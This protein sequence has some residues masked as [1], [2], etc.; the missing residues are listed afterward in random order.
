MSK[1]FFPF[2]FS[3]GILAGNVAATIA[4]KHPVK[5]FYN[6]YGSKGV[7]LGAKVLKSEI[8]QI[9]LTVIGVI[10]TFILF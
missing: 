9:I 4:V 3:A 10:L 5:Y 8:T 1:G 2:V 7:E 6:E